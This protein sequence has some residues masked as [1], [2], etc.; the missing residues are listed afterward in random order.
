MS[1]ASK[2]IFISLLAIFLAIV[3]S[4]LIVFLSIRNTKFSF[5]KDDYIYVPIGA[6]LT[7]VVEDMEQKFNLNISTK[8]KIYTKFNSLDSSIKPGRHYLSGVVSISD[9][10]KELISSM[11]VDVDIQI[12]EGKTIRDIASKLAKNK[13]LVDFDSTKFV[14]LCLDKVFIDKIFNDSYFD[15]V[16]TL[17][18]YLFP[19][20]Y[21]VKPSYN[22]EDLIKIFIGNFLDKIAPYRN[23]MSTRGLDT[24]MIIASIIQAETAYENE[25]KKVSSLYYNRIKENMSLD[26]DV[27]ISYSTMRPMRPKD[28]YSSD[29][30]NTYDTKNYKLR[31]PPTPINSPG[32]K[33]IEASIYPDKSDY[34][35]MFSPKAI[36]T[37][38][39]TK[40]YDAHEAVIDSIKALQ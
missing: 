15:N 2:R 26:S 25:M 11:N 19:D 33:A 35:F 23:D 29:P 7:Q 10:L 14:D 17:E 20:T 37:H 36:E 32:L 13:N 34:L 5:E 3:F 22:E 18:G 21:R 24:L 1:K 4:G 28:K 40:T 12:I 39:F 8:V 9:L 38:F 16:N 31:L 27:T 6:S 30:Y